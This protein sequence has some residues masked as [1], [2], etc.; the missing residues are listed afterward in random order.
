[1]PHDEIGP[2]SADELLELDNDC[3]ERDAR[4]WGHVTDTA[5]AFWADGDGDDVELVRSDVYANSYVV[6]SHRLLHEGLPVVTRVS[7][8]SY[9]RSLSDRVETRIHWNQPGLRRPEW[10]AVPG[11][12]LH[13]DGM[14][15]AFH[16]KVVGTLAEYRD[17]VSAR[18]GRV[19]LSDEPHVTIINGE[20][21]KLIY[22]DRYPLTAICKLELSH[23]A[24]G[25]STWKQK[26]HATGFLVGRRTLMTSGHVQLPDG[27]M[28]RIRVI[29]ACWANQPIFGR[30][31][32]TWVKQ[33]YSWHSD[34]GNDLQVCELYDP[35]GEQLGYFGYRHYDSDWEDLSRWTMAGFHHDM[36]IY[37]LSGQTGIAVRDDDDGDDIELDGDTYDTTQVESD[38][39]ESSGSSGSPLYGWWADG[40]Y[41]I[42]VHSGTQHDGTVSGTETLA[43]AAGGDGFVAVAGWGRAQWG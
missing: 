21:R 43:C 24:D 2:L 27:G 37:A 32:V 34:S 25:S 17:G 26:G 16:P 29:P 19:E 6:R 4:P 5:Y 14:P 36:S 15:R 22:P 3:V 10:R 40:P 33:S 9:A 42:G 8:R 11:S 7:G 18:G 35:I 41:A 30:G 23:L 38:A 28:A 13:P 12:P 1:V 31:L 39:D 20:S